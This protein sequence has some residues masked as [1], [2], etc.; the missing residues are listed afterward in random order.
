[1]T[2]TIY[3]ERSKDIQLG[4]MG[5]N[6]ALDVVFD[7][8][9]MIKYYG[10]GTCQLIHQRNGEDSGY[11][12]ELIQEGNTA[13]WRV[14]NTDVAR[15][16]RGKCELQYVV[17]NTIA[18]SEIFDTYVSDA[19]TSSGEPPEPWSDWMDSLLSA[20]A[21]IKATVTPVF[22]IHENG[23]LFVSAGNENHDLGNIQGPQGDTG[24]AGSQGPK[25]D[26]GETGPRGLKGDTGET[27]PQGPQGIQGIQGQKGDTGEQGPQGSQGIKGNDGEDGFSPVVVT[28]TI[29]GGHRVTITDAAGPHVFDVIDG[30]GAGDM[31]V[32]TYDPQGKAQDVFQYADD[33]AAAIVVPATLA[34]LTGDATHRTVTDAEKTTWSGKQNVITDLDNIRDGAAAG[35]TA[36]QTE[37]DPTVPAWA[38]ASQKP[39]YTAQEVGLGN[40]PNVATNDQTPTYTA[41]STPAELVSGE[42]LSV[43][44]GKIA[45]AITDFITHKADTGIHV[46]STEK[47]TWNGKASKP[48]TA[49]VTLGTSWTASGDNWV[50]TVSISGVTASTKVD[51]QPDA[52]AIAQMVSDSVTAL[53]F[54]NNN[55]TIQAVAVGGNP[56]ASMSVQVTLTEVTA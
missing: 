2:K 13:I 11:P 28:A 23:H 20:A 39:T 30:S 18:K 54:A 9:D 26:T 7:I 49:T 10:S 19:I 42:K 46:N 29:T 1:M 22:S 3:A 55:G 33:A 41:A 56:T 52:T 21:D 37:T 17:G 8:S 25:G 24:A 50:Q 16:G 40:V 14:K 6:N 53:Y 12:C 31:L 5:E 38:K 35:A 43:A 36:L 48:K 4:Y 47:A 32:S 45:K 51:V 34:E 15:S 44:M 27:G